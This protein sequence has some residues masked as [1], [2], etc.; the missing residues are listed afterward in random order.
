V[1]PVY[2]AAAGGLAMSFN[3]Q[4]D[5]TAALMLLPIFQRIF[6]GIAAVDP[7]L[8]PFADIVQAILGNP[9]APTAAQVRTMTD[10]MAKMTKQMEGLGQKLDTLT[11]AMKGLQTDIN[12]AKLGS[13]TQTRG[14]APAGPG[15]GNPA[16]RAEIKRL[17]A[18]I[19]ALQNARANTAT[20]LARTNPRAEIKQVLA[21]I[22]SWRAP[23]SQIL[24]SHSN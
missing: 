23:K 11:D 19:T 6:G 18:E 15:A 4:G 13:G 12:K 1:A 10:E 3:M 20:H 16:A 24:A 7:Q 5:A 8:R 14:A 9:N 21:E 22:E 17:V 2:P